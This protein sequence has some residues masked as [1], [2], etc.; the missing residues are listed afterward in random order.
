MARPENQEP[1]T[2]GLSFGA[3][4]AT[5]E[6][7]AVNPTVIPQARVEPKPA[8]VPA[9]TKDQEEIYRKER[10]WD[11]DAEERKRK[12]YV[13]PLS[14]HKKLRKAVARKEIR[15]ENDLIIFLLEKWFSGELILK[16][17]Q[18]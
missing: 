5:V 17:K 9:A 8:V 11:A 10:L 7:P 6:D 15:S 2:T 3:S 1:V 12:Q 18:D 13:I 14:L 16:E 4:G